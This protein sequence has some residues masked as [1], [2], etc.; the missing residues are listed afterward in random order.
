MLYFCDAYIMCI[1]SAP[2]L[3]Q[4]SN[5]WALNIELF[6]ALV[7]M[8][9]TNFVPIAPLEGAVPAFIVFNYDPKFAPNIKQFVSNSNKKI[10]HQS[11]KLVQIRCHNGTKIHKCLV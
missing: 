3:H 4:K 1:K 9:F 10:S 8:L 6:Y 2:Y 7:L 5:N 11:R